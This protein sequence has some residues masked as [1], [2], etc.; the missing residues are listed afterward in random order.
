MTM[1]HVP[2]SA[3]TSAPPYQR[4]RHS[5]EQIWLNYLLGTYAAH[6]MDRHYERIHIDPPKRKRERAKKQLQGLK[7][8]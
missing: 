4:D 7:D 2:V 3:L 6:F 5:K 1:A 8:E